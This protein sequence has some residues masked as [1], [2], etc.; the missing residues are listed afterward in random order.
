MYYKKRLLPKNTL[1][2]YGGYSPYE[3]LFGRTPRLLDVMPHEDDSVIKEN[4][5][6]VRAIALRSMV[7]QP[8]LRTR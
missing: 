3:A 2:Q 7:Q 5:A 8:Q 4:A 1:L 6:E